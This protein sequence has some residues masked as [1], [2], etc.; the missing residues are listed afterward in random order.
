MKVGILYESN[1]FKYKV[2]KGM[3]KKQIDFNIITKLLKLG[4]NPLGSVSQK[5]SN[6]YLYSELIPEN[7]HL[8]KLTTLFIKNGMKIKS[9]NYKNDGNDINPIWHFGFR[10]DGSGIKTLELLLDNDL[11]VESIEELVEHIYTD[12][13]FLDE[14]HDYDE[15]YKDRAF[16]IYEYAIKII[17]KNG[18]EIQVCPQPTE[19]DG[20][21]DLIIKDVNGWLNYNQI[22][23]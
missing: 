21:Y 1:R 22:E 18:V 13:I 15:K 5:D 3:W 14:A 16:K 9:S 2:I 12:Y 17:L 23:K 19:N 11:D 10:C 7:R 8:Y 4:A 6:E 20:Y